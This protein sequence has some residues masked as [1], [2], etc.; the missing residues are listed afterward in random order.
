MTQLM[1]K[2]ENIQILTLK[3]TQ[4]EARHTSIATL[5]CKPKELGLK[6]AIDASFASMEKKTVSKYELVHETYS[7]CSI[8]NKNPIQGLPVPIYQS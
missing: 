7:F 6:V 3:D 1:G 2:N 4:N 5:P 8:C